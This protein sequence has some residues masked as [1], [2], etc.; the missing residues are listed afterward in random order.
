MDWAQVLVIILAIFLAVFLLLGVVL[1]ALLIKVTKQIKAVT[2]SA[3]R[4]VQNIEG[5]VAGFGKTTSSLMMLRMLTSQ[6]KKLRK[7]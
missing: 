5:T 3:E 4:T 7:K 1:V 6:L 2:S